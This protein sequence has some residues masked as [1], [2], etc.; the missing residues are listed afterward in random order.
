MIDLIVVRSV[1]WGLFGALLAAGYLSALGWNVH[2][3]VS[4][5]AGY[6]AVLVHML[7]VLAVGAALSL[8]AHRGAHALLAS[9]AGF[10]LTRSAVVRAQ[11]RMS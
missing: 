3:Y 11:E 8:C 9:L 7:R 2:L 10:H 4:R 6:A 1:P 5:G